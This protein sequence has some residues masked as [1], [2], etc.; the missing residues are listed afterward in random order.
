VAAGIIRLLNDPQLRERIAAQGRRIVAEQ[1]DLD[2]QA[3]IVEK[4]Y[5]ALRATTPLRAFTLS[6]LI[7]GLFAAGHAYVTFRRRHPPA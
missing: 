7:S 1:A 6:A 4:R 5:R 2:Q 3:A